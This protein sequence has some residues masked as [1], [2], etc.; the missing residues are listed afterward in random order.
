MKPGASGALSQATVTARPAP[1]PMPPFKKTPPV[2]TALRDVTPRPANTHAALRPVNAANRAVDDRFRCMN[3]CL[4]KGSNHKQGLEKAGFRRF[5]TS[6]RWNRLRPRPG[7]QRDSDRL[8]CLTFSGY[9]L[10]GTRSAGQQQKRNPGLRRTLGYFHQLTSK[11]PRRS[12]AGASC[13]LYRNAYAAAETWALAG[14]EAIV[15]R[16]CEAIW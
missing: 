9:V 3:R 2:R 5:P 11:K 8:N 10:S 7:I 16:I 6:D 12:L 15:F 1:P 13:H 14:T 4:W